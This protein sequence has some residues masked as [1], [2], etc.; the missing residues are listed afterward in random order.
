MQ[1]L[2]PP[3]ECGLVIRSG[4]R[5]AGPGQIAVQP[6][7]LEGADAERGRARDKMRLALLRE[8]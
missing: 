4:R 3:K 2:V 6:D 8:M 1:R 7:E 5:R